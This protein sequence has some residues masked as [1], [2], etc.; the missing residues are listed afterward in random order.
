MSRIRIVKAEIIK[1]TD[2]RWIEVVVR[3][4]KRVICTRRGEKINWE[5]YFIKLR[6]AETDPI[7]V[8]KYDVCRLIAKYTEGRWGKINSVNWKLVG[9]DDVQIRFKIEFKRAEDLKEFKDHF[10]QV[11][12]GT[13]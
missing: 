7:L 2:N 11:V 1:T 12:N 8:E 6:D 9:Q 13:N 3:G 5:E 4:C 10:D